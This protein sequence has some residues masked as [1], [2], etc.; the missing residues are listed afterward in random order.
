MKRRSLTAVLV[1]GTLIAQLA[2][3]C[4]TGRDEG[5]A[6]Y[7]TRGDIPPSRMEALSH[8]EISD[9]PIITVKDII[10][11]NAQTHE[12]TLT[13]QAFERIASLQVPVSGISFLVCV[14]KSPLYWGAFWT[15]VSSLSFNGVTIWQPFGAQDVNIIT[16][17]L[18][19]P[20][21]SFYSGQDP[22]N[23]QDVMASLERDGKLVDSLSI[24]D[25]TSLPHGFKGYELYSW[26][27]DG[28]WKFTLITGTNRTKTIEEITTDEDYISQTGWVNIH[29][30]G[31]Y[32]IRQ[33]LEKLPAGETVYWCGKLHIG[34]ASEV[35]FEL[36]PEQTVDDIKNHCYELGVDLI[37]TI[38]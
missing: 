26:L 11:Y 12:I 20:S 32:E 27:E 14:N 16:L 37:I 7:L 30:E 18:G 2:G 34:Q 23:N 17:E 33:V 22:R 36:P 24:S 5:F 28:D 38:Y 1:L 9:T 10:S 19:Y 6:I 25:I 8:V 4:N 21:S 15:P 29:V 3:G 13:S 31:S 35:D